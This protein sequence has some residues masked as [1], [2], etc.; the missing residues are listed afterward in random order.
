M[1]IDGAPIRASL[2]AEAMSFERV[3]T[4][5]TPPF[6]GGAQAAVSFAAVSHRFL[7]L[8]TSKTDFAGS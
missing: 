3:P 7:K 8:Q 2:R 1:R 6:S 4:A 5:C